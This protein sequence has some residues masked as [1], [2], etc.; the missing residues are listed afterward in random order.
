MMKQEATEEPILTQELKQQIKTSKV[1]L[2]LR[3]PTVL[4]L[5]DFFLD[6]VPLTDLQGAVLHPA[7]ND[8]TTQM[9]TLCF[10]VV[11]FAQTWC[12]WVSFIMLTDHLVCHS[13]ILDLH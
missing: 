11:L 10:G 1:I 9:E 12:N 5:D 3:G 6:A 8:I 2:C 7:E 13:L 4:S